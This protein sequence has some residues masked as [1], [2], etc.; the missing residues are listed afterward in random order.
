MRRAPDRKIEECFIEDHEPPARHFA[1]TVLGN[2]T[3]REIWIWAGLDGE[4]AYSFPRVIAGA[5]L[6]RV[7]IITLGRK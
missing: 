1:K 2:L 6:P 3:G 5:E 7:K 4:G